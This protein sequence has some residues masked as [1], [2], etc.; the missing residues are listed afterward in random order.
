MRCLGGC[1]YLK[2]TMGT[3]RQP[4]D[5]VAEKGRPTAETL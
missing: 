3:S 5:E 4:E 1:G 2:L